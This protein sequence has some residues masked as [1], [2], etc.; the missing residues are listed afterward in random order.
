MK[1]FFTLLTV[2]ASVAPAA[3]RVPI[4]DKTLVAW[5]TPADLTQR[6]GSVLTIDDQQGHFDGIVF[7]EVAPWKWMAG[8]DGHRRTD[9][10][11]DSWPAETANAST[12]VQV[13]IVYQ[14]TEVTTYRDGKLYS[15][16]QIKAPLEFGKDSATVIGLRHL[17]ASDGACFAGAIDDARL[18]GVALTAEQVAVLKPNQPSEP[19]P[20]AW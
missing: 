2:I 14:G 19:K 1:A 11:Q 17:E 15:R 18:Y 16:S 5:V 7:G 4:K 20:V 9:K 8:S 10:Q 3:E 6:G 13:A 12:L